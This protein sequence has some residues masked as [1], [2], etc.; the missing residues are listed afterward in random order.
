MSYEG[1]LNTLTYTLAYLPRVAP[2]SYVGQYNLQWMFEMAYCERP[3]WAEKIWN[4]F[5]QTLTCSWDYLCASLYSW[6]SDWGCWTR[7]EHSLH[8]N[9]TDQCVPHWS[10]PY[11]TVTH[12]M[13]LKRYANYHSTVEKYNVF[14]LNPRMQWCVVTSLQSTLLYKWEISHS[15]RHRRWISLQIISWS[16]TTCI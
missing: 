3:E 5:F 10:N 7:A 2:T 15:L 12:V 16:R 11:E 4:S 8:Q 14:N 1:C 13:C 6:S 9:I